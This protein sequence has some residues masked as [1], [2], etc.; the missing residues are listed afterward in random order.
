[1]I[2]LS[3]RIDY[4]TEP[5]RFEHFFIYR[6]E[7]TQLTIQ[8]ILK[9]YRQRTCSDFLSVTIAKEVAPDVYALISMTGNVRDPHIPTKGGL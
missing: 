9:K 8:N 3:I 6:S 2:K 4:T 7:L 1:M 5:E